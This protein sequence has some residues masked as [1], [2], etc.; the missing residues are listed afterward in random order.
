MKPA[1]IDDKKF[2]AFVKK[3]IAVVDCWAEWCGPC[4]MMGP[5]IDRLAKKYGNRIKFGKL[6]VDENTTIPSKYDILSIPTLLVFKNGEN[7]DR[8]TGAVP[9]Q[10]LAERLDSQLK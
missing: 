7:V 3:G 2:N 1:E 5:V 6:N 10:E 4:R 8:I 9:E